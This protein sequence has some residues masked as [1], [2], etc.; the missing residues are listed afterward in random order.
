MFGKEEGIEIIGAPAPE[1]QFILVSSGF[2]QTTVGAITNAFT[3]VADRDGVDT[4]AN[5]EITYDYGNLEV[6]KREVIISSGTTMMMYNAEYQLYENITIHE[7]LVEELGHVLD[8][9]S[10]DFGEGFKNVATYENVFDYTKLVFVDSESQDVTENYFVTPIFGEVTIYPKPIEIRT[11]DATKQ[12]DGTPLTCDKYTVT[13]DLFENHY[14]EITITGTRLA[15][16]ESLNTFIVTDIIDESSGVPESVYHNYEIKEVCGV[17]YVFDANSNND[18]ANTDE[19]TGGEIDE[20][21]EKSPEEIPI[22]EVTTSVTGRVYLRQVSYGDYIVA[23][24]GKTQWVTGRVY[25]GG[26]INPM[27]FPYLALENYSNANQTV[28]TKLISDA[29]YVLP[30]YTDLSTEPTLNDVQ[31]SVDTNGY[32]VMDRSY[33]LKYYLKGALTGTAYEQEELDY[34]KFVYE[35]YTYLPQSTKQA[36][37]NVISQNGLSA[38]DANVIQK[39]ADLVSNYVSYSYEFHYEGD[40]AKYFFTQAKTGICQHYATAATAL[41]RALN[42]P[43]RYTTGYVGNVYANTPSIIKTPGHAWVEVYVDGFG[44]IP[45][46]VTGT[47]DQEQEE[48]S[49]PSSGAILVKPYDVYVQGSTGTTLT[50]TNTLLE[51]SELAKLCQEK[52][53]TY[54]FKVEG[55]QIGIGKTKTKITDFV[56]YDENGVP[57]EEGYTFNF[58]E[59]VLQVYVQELTIMTASLSEYYDGRNHFID[60]TSPDAITVDYGRWGKLI[61]GHTFG[62]V[63]FAKSIKDVG[64]VS[65]TFK[66]FSIIDALG[67]NVT[68]FYKINFIYGRLTIKSRSLT[69]TAD[70]A[71]AK[72]AD[73]NGEP[74]TCDT[75]TI[76]SNIDGLE[77]LA[78]GHVIVVKIESSISK[79]GRTANQISEIKILDEYGVDVTSNYNIVR[80]SGTLRIT[81]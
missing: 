59:G 45:V 39:V 9:N 30:Y 1:E 72:L 17:L 25:S 60:I 6:T 21:G 22:Y 18:D 50:Y 46:E 41:F 55:R 28:I 48:S 33:L 27:A 29:P 67:N 77:P 24:N 40:I 47:M 42:I 44:W 49:Q 69:V 3:L 36:M 26:T 32:V 73:L 20:D 61:D 56:L 11:H 13:G 10:V 64:S 35:N 8:V 68:D 2:S 70:S 57:I 19:N 52:G 58:K 75:Y 76:V 5:Y 79:V 74:L 78:E 14:L 53:Y 54:S 71:T 51:G 66:Q 62:K 7:G 12:Y 43:A 31:L 34:R 23:P 65:N 4:T 80:K 63:S 81:N 38:D 37:L 15:P 16:G